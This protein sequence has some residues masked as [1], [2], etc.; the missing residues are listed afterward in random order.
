MKRA[1]SLQII[2]QHIANYRLSLLYVQAPNCGVCTVFHTQIEKLLSEMPQIAGIETN[3][4]NVPSIA[5]AFQVMSAPAVLA[6]ADGKEI[7]RG[8]RFIDMKALQDIL[9][10]YS[11]EY[12][13]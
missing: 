7:W 5:G 13:I 3:I 2:Q 8:A 12:T 11:Q 1:N 6:F 4:V 9:E 10:K